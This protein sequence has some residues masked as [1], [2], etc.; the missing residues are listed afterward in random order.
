VDERGDGILASTVGVGNSPLGKIASPQ[1]G[2]AAVWGTG[3]AAVGVVGSDTVPVIPSTS[4][5]DV[6][7]A[8]IAVESDRSEPVAVGVC[9]GGVA[10]DRLIAL[11]CSS[12]VVDAFDWSKASTASS[13]F[14]A[15]SAAAFV[16][17]V[18]V[19]WSTASCCCAV[20]RSTA[21][22]SSGVGVAVD[23][24]T[25]VLV[26]VVV[27]RSIASFSNGAVNRLTVSLW[28]SASAAGVVV[29]AFNCSRACIREDGCKDGFFK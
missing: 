22:V 29:V 4:A 12:C 14:G 26:V 17:V 21:S 11:S 8:V 9:L 24:L 28:W 6:V 2:S 1:D 13:C 27:D 7:G 15:A 23:R 19:D 10:I 20:D 18:A 5:A 25:A 3:S 16:V